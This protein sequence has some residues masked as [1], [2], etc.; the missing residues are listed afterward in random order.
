VYPNGNDIVV[1]L[2]N[3]DGTLQAG[4]TYAV[5]TDARSVA[6]AD[7]NNDGK[8]DVIAAN[9]GSSNISILLGS[10]SGGFGAASTVALLA[11]SAPRAIATADVNFDGKIDVVVAN[12]DLN[13]VSVLLGNGDGTFPAATAASS[14]AVGSAPVGLSLGSF[15]GG[16][17][18]Y[19]IAT[20]NRDSSDIS[21][22]YGD[23]AGAFAA[24]VNTSLP[25]SSNSFSMAMGHFNADSIP[26]FVTANGGLNN[27]TVLL[28]TP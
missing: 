16:N 26:D 15:N 20:I 4:I 22:L 18:Q 12:T 21:I 1:H 8:M 10:G 17:L 5:G 13:S 2:G 14:Y 7:T 25:A 27:A 6:V 28:Q 9:L 19:D 11:G 3:G 23:G 24:A